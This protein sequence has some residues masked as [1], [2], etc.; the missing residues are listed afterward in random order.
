MLV[1]PAVIIILLAAHF[2]M[3]RRQGISEPL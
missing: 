1:L 2:S 3:I